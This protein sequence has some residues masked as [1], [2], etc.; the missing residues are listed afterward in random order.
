LRKTGPEHPFQPASGKISVEF[1]RA[2]LP[3]WM[4]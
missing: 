2:A 1:D 4:R 3:G